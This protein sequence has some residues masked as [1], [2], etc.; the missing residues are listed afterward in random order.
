MHFVVQQQRL[1]FLQVLYVL[2]V[3]ECGVVLDGLIIQRYEMVDG[4]WGYLLVIFPFLALGC[5]Q[6][7]L[8][9]VNRLQQFINLALLLNYALC[10][11][12]S[13][14]QLLFLFVFFVHGQSQLGK[15]SSY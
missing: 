2:L 13:F 11:D 5:L 6:H 15:L 10:R 14:T 3:V 9:L 4:G 1:Q 7:L 12:F 8:I